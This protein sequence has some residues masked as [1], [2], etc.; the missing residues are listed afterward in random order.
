MMQPIRRPDRDAVVDTGE[1][2]AATP[3]QAATHEVVLAGAAL[4]LD[5]DGIMYWPREQALVVADLHL[6]KGSSFAAP[7]Q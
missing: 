2:A 6:E 3:A 4:V 7:A 5:A 1:E